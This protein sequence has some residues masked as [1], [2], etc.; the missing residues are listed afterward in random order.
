M[1]I[2]AIKTKKKELI[3]NKDVPKFKGAARLLHQHVLDK[4]FPEL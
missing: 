1:H 4:V 2:L 3:K